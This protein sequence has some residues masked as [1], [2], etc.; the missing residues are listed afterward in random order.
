MELVFKTATFIQGYYIESIFL[1]LLLLLV[2]SKLY[3]PFQLNTTTKVF[4]FSLLIYA[5]LQGFTFFLKG[6]GNDN[7]FE[8]SNRATGSYA[9]YYW[10]WVFTTLVFPLVFF[11]KKLQTK[12]WLVLLIAFL[13]NVPFYLEYVTILV[14]S[15]LRDYSTEI[16][17]NEI[18]VGLTVLFIKSIILSF[19]LIVIDI[20]RNISFKSIEERED[21][22]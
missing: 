4:A 18:L 21:I 8:L 1:S 13:F 6:I 7:L 15:F 22:L 10:Y 16:T 2:F 11:T 5:L 12:I 19:I 14:T 20:S 3:R 9:L 17:F